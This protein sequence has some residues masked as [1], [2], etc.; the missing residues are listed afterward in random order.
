MSGGGRS[1]WGAGSSAA[2]R[3]R[4]LWWCGGPGSP[5]AEAGGGGSFAERCECQASDALVQSSLSPRWPGAMAAESSGGAGRC[6]RG[7]IEDPGD[8]NPVLPIVGARWNEAPLKAQSS[9]SDLSP[10]LVYPSLEMGPVEAAR[11]GQEG[12]Q[13]RPTSC[14]LA[15]GG[16]SGRRPRFWAKSVL[17]PRAPSTGPGNPVNSEGGRPPA[18][19]CGHS[20]SMRKPL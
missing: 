14:N 15:T 18:R 1:V 9:P 8:R 3:D 4:R 11:Q 16:L 2:S 10:G 6:L 13:Q 12:P 20:D 19:A 7:S 17:H 5:A